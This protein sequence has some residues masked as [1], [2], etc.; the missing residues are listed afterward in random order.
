MDKVNQEEAIR[1]ALTIDPKVLSMLNPKAVNMLQAIPIHR[2]S[3]GRVLVI[4]V[5]PDDLLLRDDLGKVLRGS[6]YTRQVAPETFHEIYRR[7]FSYYS[8]SSRFLA[9]VSGGESNQVYVIK[10]ATDEIVDTIQVGA[11][12]TEMRMNPDGTKLFVLNSLSGSVSVIDTSTNR[13]IAEIP[14][15]KG[16]KGITPIFMDRVYVTSTHPDAIWV[17]NTQNHDVVMSYTPSTQPQEVTLSPDG[18]KL[19]IANSRLNTISIANAESLRATRQIPVGSF[20]NSVTVSSEG[21]YLFVTNRNSNNLTVIDLS[22][23]EVIKTIPVGIEPFSAIHLP[24]QRQLAVANY[25]SSD[26]TLINL[27]SMNVIGSVPIG[28][29]PRKL[30]ATPD[31]RYLFVTNKQFNDISLIDLNLRT[32]IRQFAGGLD[33]YDIILKSQGGGE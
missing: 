26:L 21:Q 29:R 15:S 25:K 23:E 7:Y 18:K 16:V 2:G 5:K 28:G 27:E 11:S 17:I 6:F 13:V 8:I 10:L 33:P 32:V 9:Y 12:P 20:P 4:M 31:G 19:Y 22:T 24:R 30:T 14:L 1:I 3:D